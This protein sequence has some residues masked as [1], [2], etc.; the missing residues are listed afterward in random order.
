M[1]I[2][3]RDCSCSI[4]LVFIRRVPAIR[5]PPGKRDAVDN[6]THTQREVEQH[7]TAGSSDDD[8][9]SD[10]ASGDESALSA[11]YTRHVRAVYGMVLRM[12]QDSETAEEVVHEAFLR[13]WRRPGA[14]DPLRS[15]FRT[16]TADYRAPPGS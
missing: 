15:H 1:K 11:L 5:I 7:R 12:L 3:R 8:L 10:L 9:V 2:I 4:R 14:F 6:L 13:V 16:W